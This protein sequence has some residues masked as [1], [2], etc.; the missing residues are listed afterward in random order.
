MA[1]T[2]ETTKTYDLFNGTV[3]KHFVRYPEGTVLV[4]YTA[5][6]DGTESKAYQRL[7]NAINW[8]NK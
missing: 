7:G 6:R 4:H 8:L 1:N 2:T 5:I 3:V